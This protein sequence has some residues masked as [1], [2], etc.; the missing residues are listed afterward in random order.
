MD[1]G[2][3]YTVGRPRLA[4]IIRPAGFFDIK[5]GGLKNLI[6]VIYEEFGGSIDN[7]S[8]I[9]T[10]GLWTVPIFGLCRTWCRKAPLG[11]TCPLGGDRNEN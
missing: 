5:A 6:K 4:E 2:E 7:I 1:V 8:D 3:L 9:G 11:G 10:A